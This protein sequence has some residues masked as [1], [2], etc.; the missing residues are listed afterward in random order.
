MVGTQRG[1][2]TL[3][4]VVMAGICNKLEV[5]EDTGT[6]WKKK[7]VDDETERTS[8]YTLLPKCHAGGRGTKTL[9]KKPS[10]QEAKLPPLQFVTS[11]VTRIFQLLAIGDGSSY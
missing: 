10:S 7:H 8:S 5:P 11:K 6:G 2:P 3:V 4:E 1:D 9:A